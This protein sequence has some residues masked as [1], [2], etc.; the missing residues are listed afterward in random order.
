MG[1]TLVDAPTPIHQEPSGLIVIRAEDYIGSARAGL[2]SVSDSISVAGTVVKEEQEQAVATAFGGMSTR[3]AA[4]DPTITIPISDLTPF[5]TGSG[6][7]RLRI[8][9]TVKVLGDVPQNAQNATRWDGFNTGGAGTSAV[10]AVARDTSF[11]DTPPF[12]SSVF[13]DQYKL[14]QVLF[15]SWAFLSGGTDLVIK[16]W[17]ITGG[18]MEFYFDVIYIWP[19][20]FGSL[21]DDFNWEYFP[22][23]FNPLQFD[24]N[25]TFDVMEDI[26]DT[27]NALG[28]QSVTTSGE[29]HASLVLA[30]GISDHQESNDE[31]TSYDLNAGSWFDGTNGT[32]A[33]PKSRIV[34]VTGS[35][36]I[37]ATTLVNDDFSSS[38]SP[39]G[40]GSHLLTTPE[41]YT[42][43]NDL[44][45]FGPTHP[46]GREGWNQDGG[47]LHCSWGANQGGSSSYWPHADWCLGIYDQFGPD[48]TD[49]RDY[50]IT[51]DGLEDS[52][53]EFTIWFDGDDAEVI[54]GLGDFNIGSP[55]LNN[56]RTYGAILTLDGGVLDLGL[57]ARVEL[58]GATSFY[59]D[60]HY[61]QGPTNV[62]G[63]YAGEVYRIKYEKRRYI[64]RVK[65][66]EDGDSEPGSW[67]LEYQM[68]FG[69]R[70]QGDSFGSTRGWLDYSYLTNW[71]GDVLH[72]FITYDPIY[73]PSIGTY[74][75]IQAYP[76]SATNPDTRVEVDDYL[77]TLDWAGTAPD[78]TNVEEEKWDGTEQWG[79]VAVPWGSHRF[80]EGDL[81]N[82]HFNADTNGFN[83]IAWKDAASVENQSALLIYVFERAIAK[84]FRPQ[85][86]RRPY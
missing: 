61:S 77:L 53:Q 4:A 19:D 8:M 60:F 58:I 52:I 34:V 84:R 81:R 20:S 85:I 48:S 59:P 65:I 11:L 13:G 2:S 25:G 21:G 45:N 86:Y 22:L 27:D 5:M 57:G 10:I 32:P 42:K 47:V 41:N 14:V 66:W 50:N 69:W 16:A 17:G 72:D 56:S 64:Q 39:G 24:V 26:D 71:P 29:H 82:R 78:D 83:L 62:T 30:N 18:D 76:I 54:L 75:I 15:T 79:S 55:G 38:S 49:P 23:N 73:D 12:H 46:N 68:P 35:V 44:G 36:Y 80:L 37:P 67:T 40:A 70:A 74:P 6:I 28:E 33:D 9:A 63:A 3:F 31:P 43:F 1:F 51:L 7:I